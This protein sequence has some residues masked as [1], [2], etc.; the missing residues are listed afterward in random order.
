MEFLIQLF[1]VKPHAIIPLLLITETVSAAQNLAPVDYY[2]WY[3]EHR[4]VLKSIV[5]QT[6]RLNLPEIPASVKLPKDFVLP[7]S[8]SNRTELFQGAWQADSFFLKQI[9]SVEDKDSIIEGDGFDADLLIAGRNGERW[10][11]VIDS[12]I[13]SWTK[14]QSESDANPVW[15]G[16]RI[17]EAKL[18]SAL[19]LGLVD[20]STGSLRWRGDEYVVVGQRGGRSFGGRLSVSN[21][22]PQSITIRFSGDPSPNYYLCEYKYGSETTNALPA[23]IG[24]YRIQNE[25]KH[26]EWSIELLEIEVLNEELA[27]DYFSPKR[28]IKSQNIDEFVFTSNALYRDTSNGLRS[29]YAGAA[30][31][32]A[33]SHP[34]RTVRLAVL[35]SFVFFS[36]IALAIIF[37]HHFSVKQTKRT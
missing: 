3:L 24:F 23:K 37:R 16:V 26:P 28:F 11:Y 22:F 17:A 1:R 5:F 7:A 21:D 19:N 4:P 25:I 13:H 18:A 15:G 20:L 31:K 35:F 29:V 30:S 9:R 8:I 34:S 32:D 10:W 14:G 33:S 12:E 36:G 27:D 2:K 6:K